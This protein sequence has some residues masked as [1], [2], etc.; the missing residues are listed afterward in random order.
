VTSTLVI[1]E[2]GVLTLGIIDVVDDGVAVAV[3]TP[4]DDNDDGVVDEGDDANHSLLSLTS[5][6]LPLVGVE[7]PFILVGDDT[8]DVATAA[9]DAALAS[10]STAHAPINCVHRSFLRVLNATRSRTSPTRTNG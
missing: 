7:A 9:R 5:P 8:I 6:S 3:D 10:S 4:P 1:D 2:V